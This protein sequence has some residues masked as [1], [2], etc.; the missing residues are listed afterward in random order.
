MDSVD[1][2]APRSSSY[3]DWSDAYERVEE[4]LLSLRIQNKLLLSQLVAKIL[5]RAANR[6]EENP[7][8]P[9]SRLAMAE[10]VGL[11]DQWFED[12]LKEVG[13]N[14]EQLGARG[15]LALF[16]ADMPGR[17]QNEFL[18]DGPWPKEFLDA[19]Q[20][21]ILKTGPDFQKAR[22]TA[23]Q[24]DLGPV[25]AIADETWRAIDRWPLLGT[26]L[27]WSLYLGLLSLVFYLT[28]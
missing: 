25:S 28:R 24:I 8:Q 2:V 5:S 1:F 9:P 10:A 21:A 18:Q 16:L 4:Y 3:I 15:R 14:G 19:M 11:V 7:D 17:W 6:L 23:R 12:V 27:V 22:M 20:R 26:A 13:V